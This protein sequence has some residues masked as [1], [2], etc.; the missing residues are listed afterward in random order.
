MVFI[1]AYAFFE[2]L[3]A[4]K[5]QKDYEKRGKVAGVIG[6]TITWICIITFNTYILSGSNQNEE[7]PYCTAGSST[8]RNK[9]KWMFI[10]L[11]PAEI[12]LTLGDFI[13]WY[14]IKKINNIK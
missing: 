9:T 2:R 14:K 8:T 13:L 10:I 4:M 1:H 12:S 6:I 7:L 3:L 11:V 5:H